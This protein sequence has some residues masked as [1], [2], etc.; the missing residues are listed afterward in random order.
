M[1]HQVSPEPENGHSEEE[2]ASDL[3]NGSKADAVKTP[4]SSPAKLFTFSVVNSYGTANISSLPCDG[5]VLQLNRERSP[6]S[7]LFQEPRL[8]PRLTGRAVPLQLT[9]RWPSTGTPTP[10][11][12][13]TTSRRLRWVVSSTVGRGGWNRGLTVG[14]VTFQAYEKHESML[15]P[16]KKKATVALKECIELFTTMETLG[17]HDPWSD[18][19]C[20]SFTHPPLSGSRIRIK[21]ILFS[22]PG[23]VQPVRNTNRPPRSSIC[24]R[25]LA[26]WW[27][28]SRGSPIIDVGGTNWTRWWTFPSGTHT[29]THTHR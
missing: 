23:I 19:L 17:E 16:Q 4:C 2:E 27:F 29:H 11:S 5:H 9:P 26:S 28:T 10:R 15:Q 21:T 13:T 25:C 8:F 6:C 1:D 14:N 24:G 12:C 7:F 3:E 18:S 20:C 22:L